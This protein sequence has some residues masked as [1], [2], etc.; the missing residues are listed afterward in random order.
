MADLSNYLEGKFY[1]LVILGTA[2]TA[3]SG[4]YVALF[5]A[6]S[7][8]EAGTGTEVTGGSY[9]RINA[10]SNMS[11]HSN[12]VGSNTTAIE[13]AAASANWGTVTH[14]GLFDAVSGGNPLTIIKALAAS[15]VVNSG[16][17][18]RIP[19]GDLDFSIA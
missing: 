11:A 17:I 15:R 14:A 7:D 6:V 19:V 1:D 5:T 8:A 18:F 4:L 13:F 16:D 10:R 2:Y 12:G 9:A 3:P